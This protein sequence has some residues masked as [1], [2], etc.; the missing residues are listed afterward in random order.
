M[1]LRPRIREATEAR[2]SGVV[3]IL[4]VR[5]RPLAA[6]VTGG[7]EA[8]WVASLSRRQEEDLWA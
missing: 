4:A 6:V 2:L 3:P 1:L 5:A 7:H 8:G